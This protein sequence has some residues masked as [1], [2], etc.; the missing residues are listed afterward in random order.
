[1]SLDLIGFIRREVI[2]FKLKQKF[3]GKNIRIKPG[4]K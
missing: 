4:V 1:M 3:G 2:L